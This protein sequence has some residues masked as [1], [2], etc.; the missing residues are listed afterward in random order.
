MTFGKIAQFLRKRSSE[1]LAHAGSPNVTEDL[2]D[3][4]TSVGKNNRAPGTFS[5]NYMTHPYYPLTSRHSSH[6][7][8]KSQSREVR[9]INVL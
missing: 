6:D 5:N 9:A 7:T 1:K 3:S 2:Q 8:A 4:S